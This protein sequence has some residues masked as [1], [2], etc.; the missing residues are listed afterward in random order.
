MPLHDKNVI[1][2]A[3]NQWWLRGG[4]DPRE[5]LAAFQ[6]L[7]A[8]GITQSLFNINSRGSNNAAIGTTPAHNKADGWVFTSASSQYLTVGTGAIATAVPLSMVCLFTADNVTSAYPLMSL[9]QAATTN[10]QFKLEAG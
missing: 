3:G 7:G 10:S 1:G 2:I 5:C 8:T 9:S 4:V 6:P